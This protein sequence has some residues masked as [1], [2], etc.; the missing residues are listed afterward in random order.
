MAV[1]LVYISLDYYISNLSSVHL[2]PKLLIGWND[3]GV[4]SVVALAGLTCSWGSLFLG[5]NG[6]TAFIDS[7]HKPVL[8][9]FILFSRRFS[10]L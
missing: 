1:Q 2:K 9:V 8:V 6:S 3:F 4:V 5:R 7:T 10:N